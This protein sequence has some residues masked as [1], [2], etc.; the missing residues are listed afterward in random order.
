MSND[1][2]NL[3]LTNAFVKCVNCSRIATC[4]VAVHS[5]DILFASR[6]ILVVSVNI[7]DRLSN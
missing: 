7:L 1:W 6:L 3:Y 5:S 4:A 2:G